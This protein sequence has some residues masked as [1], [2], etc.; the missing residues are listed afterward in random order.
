MVSEEIQGEGIEWLFSLP[1]WSGD[2]SFQLEGMLAACRQFGNPQ[3]AFPSI[4]VAGTNGKGSTTTY[5]DSMW[6]TAGFRV[7][8]TTSPHLHRVHE[9]IQLDGAPIGDADLDRLLLEIRDKSSS[10]LSFFEAMILASFLFFR[11]SGVDIAIFEVGL[12]GRLDATNVLR[13]PLATL[14][15]S[16]GRDHEHILGSTLAEIAREKAGIVKAGCPLYI[17]ELPDEA[18]AVV[19]HVASARGAPLRDLRKEGQL[20][21][22]RNAGVVGSSSLLC[23]MKGELHLSQGSSSETLLLEP[24]LPGSHQ[25]RN[26]ALAALVGFS[27]GLPQDSIEKGVRAARWPAR[28]ESFSLQ[29][30]HFLLDG[31]HNPEG[32]EALA[33]ALREEE[34]EGSWIVVLG[35][36]KTKRWRE[37]VECILPFAEEIIVASPDSL[38]AEEGGEVVSYLKSRAKIVSMHDTGYDLLIA[39]F[40]DHSCFEGRKILCFGSLYLVSRLREELLQYQLREREG[41]GSHPEPAA[42]K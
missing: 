42:R 30:R 33:A 21:V 35:F 17:G 2:G 40:F 20:S 14:I 23:R 41:A 7:G 4:H 18:H 6:R 22:T 15:T 39:R 31:A 1:R 10:P 28:L 29:G 11:E 13:K 12:G 32:V 26:A 34:S 8:S 36:L 9:R 24:S 3:D 19:E 38:M 5:L 25:V 37:M 16:I 27:L